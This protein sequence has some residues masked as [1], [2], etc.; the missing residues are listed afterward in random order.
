MEN[1]HLENKLIIKISLKRLRE[2][3]AA[4]FIEQKMNH[5][6]DKVGNTFINPLLINNL[7]LW[8]RS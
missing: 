6:K 4:I 1:L 2:G 7:R 3:G 5:Q 8:E